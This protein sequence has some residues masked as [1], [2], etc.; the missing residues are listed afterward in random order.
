MGRKLQHLLICLLVILKELKATES[1]CDCSTT[2]SCICSSSSSC[3]CNTMGLTSVPQTLPSSITDLNLRDSRFTTLSQSDFSRYRSLRNLYLGGNNV[4]TINARAFYYQSSLA[5]LNLTHNRLT[6]LRADMF[7]GLSVLQNLYLYYNDISFIEARTFCPTPQLIQLSLSG[8]NVTSILQAT[9]NVFDCVN[10]LQYLHLSIGHMKVIPPNVFDNLSRLIHLYLHINEISSIPLDA[11]ANL[12]LLRRLRLESNQITDIQPGT[13][14][15][16]R[17]LQDLYLNS[18]LISNI[19]SATFSNLHQLQE[20]YLYSN[21]ITA[22]QSGA[23]S[24]L[25]QLRHLR[26]ENNKLHTIS[27]GLLTG[28]GNLQELQ[29]QNNQIATLPLVAY[30]KLS[31]ITTVNINNNP[32]QCDCR[33]VPFRMKMTGSHS[34]ENQTMC[35]GPNNFHGQ[36]LI[37]INPED[38]ICEEPTMVR[39]EMSGDTTLFQGQTLHLVCGS[40][41][42]PTPDITVILPSGLDATVGSGGRVTVHVNGTITVTNLTAADAG[43]Y[44]CIAANPAGSKFATLSVDVDIRTSVMPVTLPLGSTQSYDVTSLASVTLPQEPAIVRFER[45]GDT[46]LIQ[47]DTLYL[48]CEASGIPKPDISVI[49]PS[50]LNATVESGGRVTVEVNGTVTITDIT[51]ADAGLYICFAISPVGATYATLFADV[52]QNM[53]TTMA[54]SIPSETNTDAL[55]FELPVL[56]SSVCGAVAGTVLIGGIILTVC[57]KRRTKKPP[58]VP[59]HSIVFDNENVTVTM[60]GGHDHTGQGQL[61]AMGEATSPHL[62]APDVSQHHLYD[63]VNPLDEHP[64]LPPPRRGVAAAVDEDAPVYDALHYYQLLTS[65]WNQPA[66]EYSYGTQ[67]HYQSLRKT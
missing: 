5:T 6:S 53:H 52:Q 64:P 42:I 54:L 39:F 19:E 65:T 34:F 46:A 36:K 2:S 51:A 14:S 4:S 13:F 35:E 61:Q 12:S 49:L 11:F 30:D 57:F 66:E 44:I 16:L 50:G 1:N 25:P 43:L 24:N 60:I 10:G 21:Q 37:D 26:L 17:R 8:N 18:N 58:S 33:M 22:I 59:D 62:Q 47:G 7:E 40:L 45:S 41:G 28:L 27:P 56:I 15:N 48:V 67:H 23:F 38:L 31:S 32:W 20:L 9:H 3:D 63:E 55:N 29:L